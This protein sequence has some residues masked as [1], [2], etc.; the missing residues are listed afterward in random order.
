MFG[1]EAVR[2]IL[3]ANGIDPRKVIG[4]TGDEEEGGKNNRGYQIECWLKKH[5]EVKKFAVVD[6]ESYDMKLV[7]SR[8]VKTDRY[9][10]LT[11]ANVERLIQ[12]LET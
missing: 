9:V 11:Q 1:Y 3:K 2:D 10:G 6:D 8:L 4:I 12:L 5:P 7:S